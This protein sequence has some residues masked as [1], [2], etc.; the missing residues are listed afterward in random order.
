MYFTMRQLLD[1][2]QPD[3]VQVQVPL[4]FLTIKLAGDNY[5]M[6]ASSIANFVTGH[7][8]RRVAAIFLYQYLY[9]SALHKTEVLCST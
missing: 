6:S 1:R 7:F 9:C 3:Q 2:I 4:Y 8:M 5:E